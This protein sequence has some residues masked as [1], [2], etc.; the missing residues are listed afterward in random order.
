MRSIRRS[1]L[2]FL[3]PCGILAMAAPETLAQPETC[4]ISGVVMSVDTQAP[5]DRGEV[6]LIEAKRVER[7]GR[8]GT[9]RFS[10]LKPGTY[11]L[12]LQGRDDVRSNPVAVAVKAG[13]DVPAT[14][15]AS[16]HFLNDAG[17]SKDSI[18]ADISFR[19]GDLECRLEPVQ[20][21]FR[22]G[23]RPAFSAQLINHSMQTIFLVPCLDGS[24]YGIR[25]PH[26]TIRVDGEEG[27]VIP[28][29]SW[30]W[31]GNLNNLGVT[32]FVEV[33]PGAAFD[34]LALGFTR[35]LGVC[36]RPGRYTAVFHYSTNEPGLHKWMGW[37]FS[38]VLSAEMSQRLRRVP[39]LDES[40]SVNFEVEP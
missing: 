35:D 27:G 32:D 37:P 20:T 36:A 28:S 14:L 26:V 31:C 5:V 25:F 39:L 40:C 1:A 24:A 2:L 30:H 15:R 34:P 3:I 38:S 21:P 33:K 23:D 19:P 4:T 11:V 18:G 22:V 9:F 10:G 8:D 13:Q 17:V 16:S 12:K 7:L 29:G 6:T